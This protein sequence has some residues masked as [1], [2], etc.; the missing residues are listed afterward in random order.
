MESAKLLQAIINSAIDGIITI[1]EHGAIESVNRSASIIFGYHKTDIIGKNISILMSEPDRSNH[2]SYISRYQSTG[3][4]HIIGK[5]REVR[6]LKKDGTTFPFRLAVSEVK[7]KDRTLFTG[8]VHD[9]SRE[10][11]IEQRLREYSIE[12]ENIVE[13]RTRS[14]KSLINALN[15]TKDKF[16]INYSGNY[17]INQRTTT[18]D[19]VSD[20]YTW[21]KNFDESF[22]SWNDYISHPQTINT[23]LPFSLP[24]LDSLKARSE[25]PTLPKYGI[26]PTTGQYVYYSSTDWFKELYRDNVPSME[27]ALSIS[28]GSERVNYMLSGRYYHQD[29]VFRYN[30]DNFNRYNLRFKGSVKVNEWL[31]LN[32]NSDFSSYNYKY[33]MTS[34]G[35]VNAVWRLMAVSAFPVS[36]LLNP[37]GT[38]TIV[39]AYSVGDFYYGK[40]RSITNQTFI[41]NTI[42]FNASIIKNKLAFKGDFSYLYT[43]TEEERKFFPV[44]YSITPGAI[45][46]G[47]PN[48]LSN[49]TS[50]E[51]YYVA[52]LYA[53]YNQKFGN[54]SLKAMVGWN[55]EL[56]QV[57]NM[58]A[59]RDGLLVDNLPDFNLA[60]GLNYR[61]TGGGSEWAIVGVFYRLNYDYKGKY[62]LELNGR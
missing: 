48:S 45:I 61:L 4:A 52:N 19:L 55:L 51:N 14:L 2:D 41:R 60:T 47:G 1:N 17:S 25:D 31:T 28:G 56:N 7:Y 39:G 9:L 32:S 23:Q 62:L 36:P 5:G 33:P 35:G 20:G 26:N 42:G 44:P 54:H 15:M 12:L 18:P 59:Q 50:R 49:S 38:M 11:E 53:D 8:I 40:S 29:G 10:K 57:K 58:F 16:S 21:A 43:N 24:Y 6:G 46:N 22:A 3:Q 37:D 13:D 34:L 27:H 30:S